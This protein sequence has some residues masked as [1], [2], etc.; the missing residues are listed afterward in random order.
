VTVAFLMLWQLH[1]ALRRGLLTRFQIKAAIIG[2][3]VSYLDQ[4]GLILALSAAG[5]LSMP[6][7]IWGMAATSGLTTMI[8]ARQLRD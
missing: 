6:S 5:S 2:D 3:T 8:Q 7:A 1:E 4:F